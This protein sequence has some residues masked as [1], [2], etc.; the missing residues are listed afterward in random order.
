M[1]ARLKTGLRSIM[2][3]CHDGQCKRG[4]MQGKAER[5]ISLVDRLSKAGLS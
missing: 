5:L 4:D 1:Q 2:C 3:T